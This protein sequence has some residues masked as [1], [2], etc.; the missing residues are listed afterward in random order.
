MPVGTPLV[1]PVAGTVTDRENPG[2]F[3]HYQTVV[4]DSA[5]DQ[6]FI[7]G[8]ESLWKVKSGHVAANTVIGESGNT[9]NSTGP[10]LHFE[11]DLGGPPYA[12]GNDVNPDAALTTG[13]PATV[14]DAKKD[15]PCAGKTGWDAAWCQIQNFKPNPQLP[16]PV[17]EFWNGFS[18][19]FNKEHLLRFALVAT[20]IALIIVGL[21]VL[22]RVPENLPGAL[23]G[24]AAM[25]PEG[26]AIGAAA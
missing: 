15:D 23:K 19:V 6:T 1:S 16:D 25:T 17:G 4:P 14:T 21:A 18:V 8:H 7:L 9:G 3:G 5:P 22:A 2:G 24:V 10:H 12:V 11:Q 26:A 13:A 20:G